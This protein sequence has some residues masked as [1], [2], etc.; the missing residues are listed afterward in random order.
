MVANDICLFK[1]GINKAIPLANTY[2]VDDGSIDIHLWSTVNM[3]KL[4]GI[5]VQGMTCTGDVKAL[6]TAL[7]LSTEC[8]NA[9]KGIYGAV[10]GA[11]PAMSPKMP[12]AP[13]VQPGTN[14]TA[15]GTTPAAANGTTNGTMDGETPAAP[16]ATASPAPEAPMLPAGPAVPIQATRD[17]PM[18]PG[19]K[20]PIGTAVSQ[21][22]T[23]A[24][25]PEI[26]GAPDGK[27]WPT[28]ETAPE[29]ATAS[30]T[31]AVPVSP[32]GI[33]LDGEFT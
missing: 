2:Y 28:E 29:D 25:V 20:A 16:D 22:P 30:A 33:V 12:V 27:V 7:P 3:P 17:L 13:T 10:D 18:L 14:T 26:I 24:T 5:I 31:Y 1:N 23:G 9:A 15:N 6:K 11:S 21:Y 19:S 32:K 4:G 8:A